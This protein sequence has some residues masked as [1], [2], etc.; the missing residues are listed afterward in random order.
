MSARIVGSFSHGDDE[1][2]TAHSAK[3]AIGASRLGLWML[4]RQPEQGGRW[5]VQINIHGLLVFG[6]AVQDDFGSLQMVSV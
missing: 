1:P 6:L 5:H 2:R 3:L 4:Q